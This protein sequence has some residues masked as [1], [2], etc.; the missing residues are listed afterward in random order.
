MRR[1]R[2]IVGGASSEAMRNSVQHIPEREHSGD[3]TW[4]DYRSYMITRQGQVRTGQES[5][6]E[7]KHPSGR[8]IY[9]NV[10]NE[11]VSPPQPEGTDFGPSRTATC[12]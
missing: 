12:R 4:R 6:V 1:R 11:R 3:A 2:S 5:F 9:W 8:V 10:Y 7:M